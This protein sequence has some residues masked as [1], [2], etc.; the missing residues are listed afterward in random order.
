MCAHDILDVQGDQ[1]ARKAGEFNVDVDREPVIVVA[2]VHEHVA[3]HFD[4]EEGLDLG[5]AEDYEE[6]CADKGN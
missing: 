6:D 1:A 2:D 5:N 4:R 3:L